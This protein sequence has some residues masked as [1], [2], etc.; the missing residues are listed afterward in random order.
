M[1]KRLVFFI[2]LAFMTALSLQAVAASGFSDANGHWAENEITY[3]K[4][5]G[6][7]NG[8]P[9]GTFGVGNSITRAEVATMIANQQNLP[10]QAASFPDVTASHWA[11]GTIGA[12]AAAG[13]MGGYPDG[14][15]RPGLPLTRAEA[16]K[17]LAQAYQLTA[18]PVSPT[19]SDVSSSHWAY[20]NIEALVANYIT[21]GYPDGT[22]K[23]SNHVTR[24]EF[25]V[26]LA[27]VLNPSFTQQLQLLATTANVVQLL[28]TED[29]AGLQ[30]YIHPLQGVRFSPYYYVENSHLTFNAAAIPGL[31]TNPTVYTWGTED[32]TGD[33]INK[34]GLDYFNR[35]VMNKDYTNPDQIVYNSIVL[36]GSM[37][38]NI[39]S[40]YPNA[41]FVEYFVD[42]TP[43]YGG[44]D[45]GSLYII[46]EQ[47]NNNWYIVGIVHGEW[48]T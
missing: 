44:L 37:I 21:V 30:P 27:R 43:T 38:N 28:S 5:A 48:T 39:Q 6:I 22:F 12:V 20:A 31:L 2:L 10:W 4:N 15:F 3:L 32:G 11:N 35:Y 26:F 41:V 40:F 7:V 46:Y 13:I 16:A 23:P 33:P 47:H 9:N 17:V 34:N 19:F 42:G 36:R 29:M 24:A 45:W 25:A 14:T 1:R 18:S 8:Y